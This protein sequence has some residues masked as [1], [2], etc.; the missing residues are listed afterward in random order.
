MVKDSNAITAATTTAVQVALRIRPLT[1]RD[2]NQPR[3]A[4]I[5]N[6]DVL[7]IHDKTVQIVPQNKLFTFD[8]V[9]G[10][11][12]TQEE[13]FTALGDSLIRK[14][15]EGYNITILAY[16]QTSSGKTYTM[17]TA[18]N[19]NGINSFDEG[20]VPRSMAL[21]FD[22]LN[23][24]N[25]SSRSISPTTSIS[26][27]TSASTKSGSRLRPKSKVVNRSSHVPHAH[28]SNHSNNS[29]HSQHN[30]KFTVKVSFIEIYNEDLHDLLNT[31][32][33]E[34]LPPIT[35]REDTK[36][37][38]YWTGVKEVLVNSTDDVLYYLEQGTQ[39][40][41]TGATDM[42]EK[43]SRSHAIFSVS[44]KQE[45]WIPSATSES[46]KKSRPASSLSMRSSTP[47]SNSRLF[48]TSQN[49]QQHDEG[50]WLITT[51]KFHFVDLAGSE[52]LKRTAA[53]G[54]RRKEGININA[55]LLALGNVI[56]ALGDP[57]KKNPHVPYRDSKLTRLLQDSLGG[58]AT[59]LMIAC[60]SP[61][62]YNLAETLN[63][64]Q[65]ANRARNIKNRSEKNQVEEWMTT[66]NIELLRTMIA[67]LKNELNYLKIHSSGKSTANQPH[68]SVTPGNEDI[69]LDD[70][71]STS[72]SNT[73]PSLEDTYH[74][75][76]LLISDLQR[77][78]E[79]LDGEAS[80]TRERNRIVEKELQRVR[81]LESMTRS[82]KEEQV[83][84]QHL[85]EP[86][87]EEYEKSVAKLESQLAL[88][89]AALHHSDTGY[90]EQQVK[91]GQLEGFIRTQESS[92][93][94]LRLRL[95]KVLEREH[96]NESY[97][98]ELESKLMNSAKETTRDQDMLNELK[99]RIMKFKETD[100][101]TEQYIIELEQ[102]LAAGEVERARLQASVEDLETRIE[103]KERTNVELLRRLSKTASNT[104]TEKLILKELDE[105][106]A[107]YKDLE[108]E[109]DS[110]Q[111]QISQLQNENR[112]MSS[113]SLVE[114]RSN[115]DT[116]KIND[117]LLQDELQSRRSSMHNNVEISKNRKSFADETETASSIAA[118]NLLQAEIRL[119]E[120]A[121]RANRLQLTLD[122]LQHDH[123]ETVKELDD[124]L[125]RYHETSEQLEFMERE[126]S[127][128]I[129]QPPSV[130]KSLD[131]GKEIAQ[132]KEKDKYEQEKL[133][134]ENQIQGLQ[135]RLQSYTKQMAIKDSEFD[136]ARQSI[137][138]LE[139]ELATAND[140]I[141]QLQCT[142]S[143]QETT[144]EADQVFEKLNV[145]SCTRETENGDPQKE[146]KARLAAEKKQSLH[147]KLAHN[148]LK[149]D[150]EKLVLDLDDKEQYIL[151]LE[152]NEESLSDLQSQLD[153]SNQQSSFLQKRLAETLASLTVLKITHDGLQKK[154]Q[155]LEKDSAAANVDI[156][157][158][159]TI[160][161]LDPAF[162]NYTQDNANLVD[163]HQSKLA[164][165][166]EHCMEAKIKE[167]NTLLE[168]T[169]LDKE[170]ALQK[171]LI[172]EQKLEDQTKSAQTNNY[173]E[174]E[175]ILETHKEHIMQLTQQFDISSKELKTQISILQKELDD[176]KLKHQ[177]AL[178]NHGKDITALTA[179]FE[180]ASQQLEESKAVQEQMHAD[181]EKEVLILSKNYEDAI[182][183]L[184]DQISG[185]ES[186]L[187]GAKDLHQEILSSHS[188]R[189]REVKLEQAEISQ[190]QS[191][192]LQ[193]KLER[194]TLSHSTNVDYIQSQHKQLVES[195]E[196]QITILEL[197]LQ[198]LR[199]LHAEQ[200]KKVNAHHEE[201][202]QEKI[203]H[204]QDLLNQAQAEIV[205]HK[206]ENMKLTA[207]LG[208]QEQ[209]I[210]N[211]K[212]DNQEQLVNINEHHQTVL[213]EK[214]SNSHRILQQMQA[215]LNEQKDENEKL[216][217]TLKE[218]T[219]SLQ[220]LEELKQLH[221]DQLSHVK[222]QHKI[223]IDEQIQVISDLK[224]Q[225]ND[226]KDEN[227]QL[228]NALHE[229]ERAF[230]E[231]L[232]ALQSRLVN[233]S[234]SQTTSVPFEQQP[235]KNN[236]NNNNN[237]RVS[238]KVALLE[239]QT[240]NAQS[241][242][243]ALLK[244]QAS[245][246]QIQLQNEISKNKD[247]AT[248]LALLNG[249]HDA[250]LTELSIRHQREMSDNAGALVAANQ[251]QR[252]F[253]YEMLSGI[254]SITTT[255]TTHDRHDELLPQLAYPNITNVADDKQ[256]QQEQQEKKKQEQ[257]I[258]TN[259][260]QNTNTTTISALTR[261]LE[262]LRE[263]RSKNEMQI[264]QLR[265]ENSEYTL[266][267]SE[268]E[269]EIDRMTHRIEDL[270][271]S[272]EL[273]HQLLELYELN[274]R[275][276]LMDTLINER[277]RS[278]MSILRANTAEAKS[279]AVEKAAKAT[280]MA[281]Q[282]KSSDENNDNNDGSGAISQQQGPSSSFLLEL[283]K[284]LNDC[285]KQIS[286]MV[287]HDDM[288]N[289]QDKLNQEKE[290]YAQA[291]RARLKLEKQ[292]EEVLSKRK[293]MCF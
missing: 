130:C 45:K 293:F 108:E 131:L 62:E 163:E 273:V 105:I 65:Y 91:I 40:R 187:E 257:L 19:S 87:I 1:N 191:Q 171:L 165:A 183:E 160:A 166:A 239:S 116:T 221:M 174:Q 2:R 200:L 188:Q 135:H 112:R 211:L 172:L 263:N 57:S 198:D 180:R 8:H 284:Q 278:D 215:E 12:S 270:Q 229:Q 67:K 253:Q 148:G 41:A 76:R 38:I 268:L 4:N 52:R 206:S 25:L 283:E 15:I 179:N 139:K 277:K 228:S 43:S 280:N 23:S 27:S 287:T 94:E 236:I 78:L 10:T 56:S 22:L 50:E 210:Q 120:E 150:I 238:K 218:Q 136:I 110:L 83:D 254:T 117:T 244:S 88:A 265:E 162:S 24:N 207:A 182:C 285:H 58:S 35:I 81:L 109:R 73:S 16:G 267:S 100:E 275:H 195:Q 114:S 247:L 34:E 86:V 224:A 256:T 258:N 134:F 203:N 31:A 205:A 68:I 3:F 245:P 292:L 28:H 72:S 288:L 6:D 158:N 274:D 281:T 169:Q 49:S 241:N 84:F 230:K 48:N 30:S 225:L 29:N 204:R 92:I 125:Q 79:E 159:N 261:E 272:E 119:K 262:S 66:E 71:S 231:E 122:R 151:R 97:I 47:M 189:L 170:K 173:Q 75:Q 63:T 152:Q 95:S 161:K 282:G 246:L 252:N 223:Y 147:W 220:A 155:L 286:E 266:L 13:I 113:H 33:I 167:I 269:K 103:A 194:L 214:V 36:G 124:V 184:E 168:E 96:S 208:D 290:K 251:K 202:V 55:G 196:E 70:I 209:A 118:L 175:K 61:V 192:E 197:E 259:N 226:Y 11:T 141:F 227:S 219:H 193:A 153:E 46:S 18:A 242:N 289:L 146:L 243:S 5:A 185:L 90:E 232:F 115:K 249:K 133:N 142:E 186:E 59:T 271:L 69:I 235:Q 145:P 51:S 77:Q 80:V 178:N 64:L 107:K 60:A 156:P 217:C 104:S 82:N 181:H 237:D 39:N 106:N 121:D 216:S 176:F 128:A 212:K 250:L 9:F 26:S 74:E 199:T 37:R 85:V 154:L 17:G 279:K 201:Y 101:N 98:Q 111:L 234:V 137:Q 127:S 132:A 44:L 222:F 126:S 93:T 32:P 123:K 102:R 291:E 255:K 144:R 276:Q 233:M 129:V 143:D 99:N 14:F 264:Q 54:D 20:I 240:A 149:Q 157:E 138:E 213:D 190:K 21:L 42:N 164:A 177:A 7:K 53:E 140:R 248:K 260:D 89:R